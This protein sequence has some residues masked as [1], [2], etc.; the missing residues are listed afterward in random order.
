MELINSIFKH[1]QGYVMTRYADNKKEH[2]VTDVYGHPED[3]KHILSEK[4]ECSDKGKFNIAFAYRQGSN[5]ANAGMCFNDQGK[6]IGQIGTTN[7]CIC[8]DATGH[9]TYNRCAGGYGNLRRYNGKR[10][11]G[12]FCSYMSS[13]CNSYPHGVLGDSGGCNIAGQ[14]RVDGHFWIS[15]TGTTG[16]PS[17]GYGQ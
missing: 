9:W 3:G 5:R 12:K 16:T 2:H 13:K 6:N 11:R 4:H 15:H 17:A 1:S 7:N 8:G 14:R 10:S